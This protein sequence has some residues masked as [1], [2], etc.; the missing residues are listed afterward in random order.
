MTLKHWCSSK[1]CGKFCKIS[2]P[3]FS[4]YWFLVQVSCVYCVLHMPELTCWHYSSSHSF[5]IKCLLF[6]GR[7]FIVCVCVCVCVCLCCSPPQCVFKSRN[8]QFYFKGHYDVIHRGS[9]TDLFCGLLLINDWLT[10]H[11]LLYYILYFPPELD[12][13]CM[14]REL[15]WI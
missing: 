2:I 5:S 6:L 12:F 11:Y 7:T 8:R 3:A 1:T 15:I 14:I 10:T 13:S 4:V 9:I